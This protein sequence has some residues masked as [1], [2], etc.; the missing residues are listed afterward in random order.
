MKKKFHFLSLMFTLLLL[1]ALSFSAAAKNND[2]RNDEAYTAYLKALLEESRGNLSTAMAEL[3]KAI[4]ISPESSYLYKTG[5]ELAFRNSQYDK[6]VEMVEKAL[7][8]D[9]NNVKLNI[10]AGQIYWTKGDTVAAEAKLSRALKLAPD[11]AEA[12]VS[13]AVA[14]SARDPER[15]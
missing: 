15:A 13:L 1:P 2:S 6:A 3:E 11:E 14:V 7:E 8:Y 12:L 5:A 10:M 9:P 4:A